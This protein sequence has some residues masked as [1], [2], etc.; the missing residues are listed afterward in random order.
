MS[1][2][3]RPRMP[4]VHAW[5]NATHSVDVCPS[6][7]FVRFLL[8]TT[9]SRP[10]RS[11]GR[12][13]LVHG[14]VVTSEYETTNSCCIVSIIVLSS[15][16]VIAITSINPRSLNLRPLPVILS[17]IDLVSF[18]CC[19]FDLVMPVTFQLCLSWSSFSSAREKMK[20]TG[21]GN[22]TYSASAS[23]LNHSLVCHLTVIISP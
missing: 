19:K 4:Q 6:G 15:S 7:C 5:W 2:D 12:L 10:D 13:H 14:L 18:V 8:L 23:A 16:S 22:L 11:I 1:M 20:S 21:D 3:L 17:S 9:G